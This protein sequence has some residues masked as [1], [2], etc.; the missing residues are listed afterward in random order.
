MGAATTRDGQVSNFHAF[1]KRCCF[2]FCEGTLTLINTTAIN[3]YIKAVPK[4]SQLMY[5]IT[6]HLLV[7]FVIDVMK[8][9][10]HSAVTTK[11]PNQG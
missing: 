1:W 5:R 7:I 2:M 8:R 10:R 9:V 3:Q 11:V 4:P 6:N